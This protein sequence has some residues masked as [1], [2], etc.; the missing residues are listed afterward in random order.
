LEQIRTGQC[1]LIERLERLVEAH[2]HA[3]AQTY[4]ASGEPLALT[5]A[6]FVARVR[7]CSHALTT[8]GV[9]PQ[10]V[11]AFAER[12]SRT[13]DPMM[14]AVMTTATFSPI[15]YF[16]EAESVEPHCHRKGAT[17]LLLRCRDDGPEIIGKLRQVRDALPHLRL[18]SF[19]GRKPRRLRQPMAEAAR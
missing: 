4:I 1:N 16:F 18:V 2:G 10:D 7:R 19:G 9:G 6:E 17:T 14:I 12:L 3:I 13:S 8:L 11:V 5:F 15:N